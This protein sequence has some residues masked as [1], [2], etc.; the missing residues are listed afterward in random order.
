MVVLDQLSKLAVGL[1]LRGSVSL[2]GEFLKLTKVYNPDGVFGLSLGANFPYE[3]VSVVAAL[4]LFVLI[5]TEKRRGNILVFGL[6]LGGALGNLIDRVRWGMVLDFLDLGVSPR[7]RWPVFNI[8]DSAITI[9]LLAFLMMAL[10]R[11][12]PKPSRSREDS[13]EEV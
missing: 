9:G 6:V 10:R 2:C 5:A 12:R 13:Q 4:V 8:A 7:L 3:W 1:W 11:E